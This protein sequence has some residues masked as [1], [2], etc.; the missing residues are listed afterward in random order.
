VE[1]GQAR[2]FEQDPKYAIRLLVDVAIRALSPAVNDP[3]TAVQALDQIEDLLI[4]LGRRRLGTGEFR[5][6]QGNLRLFMIVPKWE[7]FLRLAL[8]EIRLYGANSV[9]VMRR[10]K[11]LLSELIALLPEDRHASVREW[12]S[13]LQVTINRS[14]R[15][16]QDKVEASTEDRQGMGVSRAKAA[17]S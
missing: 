14:F 5:D 13:R 16:Q 8:D 4:R 7:D 17:G 1:L 9:Q 2:T 6:S 11:A 3:T 15:A 10:M 12:Q